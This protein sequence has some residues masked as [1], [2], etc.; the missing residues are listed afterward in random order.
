MLK[1]AQQFWALELA[2]TLAAID[3]RDEYRP[4]CPLYPAPG[5]LE[6]IGQGWERGYI[7]YGAE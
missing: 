7:G 5:I 6:G 2:D 1:E 3:G 4:G